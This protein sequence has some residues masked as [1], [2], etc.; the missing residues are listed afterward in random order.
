[1]QDADC[2]GVVE[3]V[4]SASL[5][6]IR[7]SQITKVAFIFSDETIGFSVFPRFS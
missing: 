2:H 4:K 7:A 3:L 1:M 5:G 6:I